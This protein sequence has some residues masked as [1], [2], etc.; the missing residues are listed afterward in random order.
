M[1]DF[2]FVWVYLGLGKFGVLAKSCGLLRFQLTAR[3]LQITED[4]YKIR[5]KR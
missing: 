5:Y 4:I 2:G 3:A 1:V